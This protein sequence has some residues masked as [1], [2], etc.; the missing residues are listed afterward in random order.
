MILSE[1]WNGTIG[2]LY[3]VGK[4]IRSEIQRRDSRGGGGVRQWK[5]RLGLAAVSQWGPLWK[6]YVMLLSVLLCLP[7]FGADGKS[8]SAS[9]ALPS[10]PTSRSSRW[11]FLSALSVLA[12]VGKWFLLTLTSHFPVRSLPP[13]SMAVLHI[14]NVL[15]GCCSWLHWQ[16]NFIK[17]F[18]LLSNII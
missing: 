6:V 5:L 8:S 18:P 1:D 12:R 14:S 11:V 10:S 13:Y 15:I 4:D 17:Q 9:S 2:L 3:F 16:R 7:L